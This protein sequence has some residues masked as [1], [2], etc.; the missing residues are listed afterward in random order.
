MKEFWESFSLGRRFYRQCF[1]PITKKHNLSTIELD[2]IM[3][4]HQ[5]P[6]YD[7]A[8]DI[9]ERRGIA[10]PNV[11]TALRNLIERRFVEGTPGEKDRRR[12]HLQLLPACRPI[13]QDAEIAREHFLNT[14][15]RGLSEDDT[16]YMRS[17]LLRMVDNVRHDASPT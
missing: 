7:T 12:I 4:L 2:I 11:S 15:F 6:A 17:L 8:T 14:L 16:A 3:F 5:N 13:L 9:T 1:D 10:K